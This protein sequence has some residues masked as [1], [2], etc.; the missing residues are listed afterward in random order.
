MDTVDTQLKKSGGAHTTR[1]KLLCLIF[2]IVLL[3]ACRREKDPQAVFDRAWNAFQHGDLAH[4]EQ[5]ANKG[6]DRFRGLGPDWAWKFAILRARVLYQR[7]LNEDVLKVLSS[8]KTSVPSGEMEVQKYR[9]EGLASVSLRRFAEAE[10]KFGEAEHVCSV[11][12]YLPCA[13][14][15]AARGMLE[16]AR[17]NFARAEVF[18]GR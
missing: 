4:A 13:D 11:S 1:P 3:F 2:A 18:F 10:Q 8:E 16:M 12:D 7:G 9:F 5:E 17:G 6:Y 15:V 14:I